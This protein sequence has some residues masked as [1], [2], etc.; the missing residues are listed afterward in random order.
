M[1]DGAKLKKADFI[2][3]TE[4]DIETTRLEV[5]KVASQLKLLTPKAWEEHYSNSL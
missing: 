1:P 4:S 2:V 5:K 3:S